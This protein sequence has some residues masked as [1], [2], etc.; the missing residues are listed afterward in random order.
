[1]EKILKMLN[2]KNN[3][4]VKTSEFNYYTQAQENTLN[5]KDKIINKIN[6]KYKQSK[7]NE[8]NLI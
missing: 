7:R 2:S 8:E 6:S 3:L 1:M 5:K 4:F